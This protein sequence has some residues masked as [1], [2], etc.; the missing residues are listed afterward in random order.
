MRVAVSITAKV[1]ASGSFCLGI[2]ASGLESTHSVP[3]RS[4][5]LTALYAAACR[6]FREDSRKYSKHL[7][8]SRL[9][10]RTPKPAPNRSSLMPLNPEP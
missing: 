7:N 3:G 10:E 1:G 5:E 4:Q 2:G 6:R 8:L 9:H